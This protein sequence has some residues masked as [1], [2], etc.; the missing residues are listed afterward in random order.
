M[1]H[2]CWCLLYQNL[3]AEQS[4]ACLL[5]KQSNFEVV[6]AMKHATQISSVFVIRVVYFL[7][8]CLDSYLR[9]MNCCE[10]MGDCHVGVYRCT[11]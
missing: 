11:P 9:F 4:Y 10:L 3:M 2:Y 1:V 5:P 7:F 8:H 6:L